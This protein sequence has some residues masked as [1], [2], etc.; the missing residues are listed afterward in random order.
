MVSRYEANDVA[1]VASLRVRRYESKKH[2]VFH[3]DIKVRGGIGSVWTFA[4]I[5]PL[6]NLPKHM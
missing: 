3:V 2:K 4:T 6:G 5:A 1:H